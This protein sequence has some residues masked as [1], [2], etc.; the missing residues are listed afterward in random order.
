MKGFYCLPSTAQRTKILSAF[1]G[2]VRCQSDYE[3]LRSEDIPGY[4]D[5]DIF[6]FCSGDNR[7]PGF[8][9]GVS[10]AFYNNPSN[11]YTLL[12]PDEFLTQVLDLETAKE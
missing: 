5:S 12:T 1:Q 7:Y 6:V 2:K 4:Q 9:T 10:L 8:C 3:P 11:G